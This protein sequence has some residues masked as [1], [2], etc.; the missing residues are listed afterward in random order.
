MGALSARP[1]RKKKEKVYPKGDFL[2]S[3]L[4]KGKMGLTLI[5]S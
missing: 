1:K 3:G 4:N 5:W 2:S